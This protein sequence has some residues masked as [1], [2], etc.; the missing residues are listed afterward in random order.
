[1]KVVVPVIAGTALFALGFVAGRTIEQRS[2]TAAA[3]TSPAVT[4]TSKSERGRRQDGPEDR[5]RQ[6]APK[7]G[8][9]LEGKELV[10]GVRQML[11]D[12]KEGEVDILGELGK[13]PDPTRQPLFD[14]VTFNRLVTSISHATPAELEEIRA[15]FREQADDSAFAQIWGM[16]LEL[17]CQGREVEV[18]GSVV[19][20]RALAK[21]RTKSEFEDEDMLLTLP[22]LVFSY[23]R[24]APENARR[25]VEAAIADGHPLPEGLTEEFLRAALDR[26]ESG[27]P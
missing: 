15:T 10:A 19:L 9:L 18:E 27:K 8:Q 2:T 24:I 12:W 22:S 23:A 1:M 21:A 13:E 16:N 14:V 26:A 17:Q 3:A 20:D 11:G 5:D 25:W 4:L 6:D 7:R